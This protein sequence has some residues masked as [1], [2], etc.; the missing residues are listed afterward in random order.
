MKNLPPLD[1]LR[2]THA[3]P[4][5]YT[6][7]IIVFTRGGLKEEVAS[8]LVKEIREDLKHALET[9]ESSGGKHTAITIEAHVTSAEEVHLIYKALHGVN[10]LVLVL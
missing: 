4:G 6:F 3:F 5:P 9:R 1:L 2:Q 8:L 7:K 10:E